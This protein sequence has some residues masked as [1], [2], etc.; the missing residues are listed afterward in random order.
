MT[1]PFVILEHNYRGVHWDF[2]LQCGTVLRTWA[3]AAEPE[4]GCRVK[5]RA[6]PDHRLA[7]LD[8]EGPVSGGRGDVT[9]WDRGSYEML[10]CG[11]ELVVVQLRGAHCRGKATLS[12]E[13]DSEVWHF[14]LDAEA[15]ASNPDRRNSD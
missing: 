6:L 10:Q 3:L 15:E 12:R 5:A 8:Y 7:Y 4:P 13:K 2:M 14:V 1:S 9:C 11:D